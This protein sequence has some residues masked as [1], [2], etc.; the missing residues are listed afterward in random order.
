LEIKQ[1]YLLDF[2]QTQQIENKQ[3]NER[4]Q[5]IQK[6]FEILTQQ[7]QK[8]CSRRKRLTSNVNDLL[9]VIE[10]STPIQS[11]AEIRM[12]REL[13]TYQIQINYLE[14]KM[15]RL[16]QFISSNQ[17]QE[18]FDNLSMKNIQNFVQN[19]RHQIDQMKKQLQTIQNNK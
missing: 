3:L 1:R 8:E 16:Q 13:E 19:H 17:N 7:Y 6:Q 18:Q 5:Q 12:Q 15:N 4:F 2:Q 11:D 14:E 10:Q 9:S